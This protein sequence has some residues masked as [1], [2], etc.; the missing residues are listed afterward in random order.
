[1]SFFTLDSFLNGVQQRLLLLYILMSNYRR[2]GSNTVLKFFSSGIDLFSFEWV[3]QSEK[4]EE[5]LSHLPW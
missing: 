1:M 5:S 2:L 3:R 4:K